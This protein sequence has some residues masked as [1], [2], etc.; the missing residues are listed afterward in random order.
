MWTFHEAYLAKELHYQFRDVAVTLEDMRNMFHREW[1]IEFHRD[2][3]CDETCCNQGQNQNLD[4]DC[5]LN[6]LSDKEK[7]GIEMANLL[8]E[9]SFMFLRRVEAMGTNGPQEDHKRLKS[10]IHPLRW[11]TTSRM[12]DE[13]ICLSGCIDRTVEDLDHIETATGRMKVFLSGLRSV[14]AAL[15]FVDRP[16]IDERGC[17]WMPLSL[18]SGGNGS[19][20]PDSWA[21][22]E[23]VGYPTAD[24]LIVT[25][26]GIFL[27]D[28]HHYSH[29]F[30][31]GY[32]HEIIFIE[33]D[34]KA[35]FVYPL[36]AKSIIWDDYVGMHLALIMCGQ[37][38]ARGTFAVLVSMRN[39]SADMIH[40]DFLVCAMIN[41]DPQFHCNFQ[42][43]SL[44]GAVFTKTSQTNESQIWCVG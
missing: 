22:G 23:H 43:A 26:P 7:F 21:G 5:A 1:S 19:T 10:I 11:R 6:T 35:F 28:V 30:R 2:Y 3:P 24:S 34:G 38:D 44:D 13:T 27:Q 37:L 36:L 9:E 29:E 17:H 32:V 42:D 41:G 31:G 40:C 20:L 39:R 12:K 18:L 15:L 8:W 16:R 14:P 25:L 4:T 33:E